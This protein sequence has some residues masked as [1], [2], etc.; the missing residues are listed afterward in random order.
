MKPLESWLKEYASS[1]KHPVNARIHKICVPLITFSTL[2]LLWCIPVPAAIEAHSGINWAT[3]LVV[4]SLLFYA[5]LDTQALLLM[6][7]ISAVN[8]ALVSGLDHAGVLLPLASVVFLV[9]WTVQIYGH[10]IEGTKP[11]FFKDLAFLLIGPI[12]V[13]RSG[14]NALKRHP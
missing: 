1:H 11:S 5:L 3:L 2:G 8:L 4:G 14:L 10:R 6:A 9:A 12:W 13:A 7:A